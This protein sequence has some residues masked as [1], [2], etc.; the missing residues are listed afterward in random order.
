MGKECIVL[1]FGGSVV[2]SDDL[3]TTFFDDLKTTIQNIS[4]K[5]RVFI[6]VGG[7]KTARTYITLG[8]SQGFSE[9]NLDWLGINATRI[10]ARF[11]SM[12]LTSEDANVP[13]T[14]EEAIKGESNIVVMG[15]TTPGHSTD[16]VGAALA[17]QIQAKLFIIA[18]NVDGVYDK[19]PNKHPDARKFS[20][21]SIDTLL[22]EY[23]NQ[24]ETAGKN[25]VIDGPALQKIKDA[26]INTIVING[27][28]LDE[29]TRIINEK[30][31]KGT[32][33]TH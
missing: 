11:L 7:G 1:S 5:Y 12:L 31:F 26:K 18:T 2:L 24:W 19:D 10:N 25:M 28:H 29:L 4:E 14:I 33:I 21:I 20:D 30:P 13:L 15:G 17:E 3:T 23:G 8:R 16:F 32:T 6:I 9:S 27:K 22:R